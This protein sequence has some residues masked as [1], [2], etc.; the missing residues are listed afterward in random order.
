MESVR[1]AVEEK[2][3]KKFAVFKAISFTT[4]VVA[5][6]NYIMKVKCD[7]QIAHVKVAKPLPHTNQ[8]PFL[9]NVEAGHS[10][11]SPIVPF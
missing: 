4:Q 9:M 3:E 5:G 11:E 2:L 6:V 8:P 10:E 7:D 1:E